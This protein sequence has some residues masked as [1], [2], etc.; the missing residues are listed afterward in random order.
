M[1]Y[2][3]KE[4]FHKTNRKHFL[5]PLC[6]SSNIFHTTLF[7]IRNIALHFQYSSIYST[8]PCSIQSINQ[9]MV[10]IPGFYE[11]VTN[12]TFYD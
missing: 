11:C 7:L 5:I 1:K 12:T 2:K 9:I 10:K 8:P 4:A 3:E 6:K